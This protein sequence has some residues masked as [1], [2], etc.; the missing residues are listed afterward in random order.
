MEPPLVT[1]VA[2]RLRQQGWPL[3]EG[4]IHV[5]DLVG[6]LEQTLQGGTA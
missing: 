6:L 2:Q 4:L 5:Q 3:P 1:R